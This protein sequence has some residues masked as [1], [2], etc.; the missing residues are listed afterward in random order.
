VQNS[1]NILIVDDCVEFA[2]S[3]A[4]LLSSVGHRV[5]TS[6]SAD[7]CA[8]Q[9]KSEKFDVIIMDINMY[10]VDGRELAFDLKSTNDLQN[11]AIIYASTR[12]AL[13]NANIVGSEDNY[14]I[15]PFTKEQLFGAIDAAM[16]IGT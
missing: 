14:L 7:N 16:E 4:T 8:E 15:K 13:L 6:L 10:D 12:R 11:T 1:A 9:V 2:S 5:A 3:T